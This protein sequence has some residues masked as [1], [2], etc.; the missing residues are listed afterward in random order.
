MSKANFENKKKNVNK[1][2]EIKKTRDTNK[3]I[4]HEKKQEK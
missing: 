1:E 2:N 4:Q 3:L